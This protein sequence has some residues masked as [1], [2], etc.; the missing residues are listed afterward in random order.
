MRSR[1]FAPLRAAWMP[2]ARGRRWTVPLALAATAVASLAVSGPASANGARGGVTA[3][4]ASAA[5]GTNVSVAHSNGLFSAMSPSLQKIYSN[6]PFTLT[7]S[8]WQHHKFPKGPWKVGFIGYP[9]VNQYF[10][11]RLAGLKAEFAAAKKKGLVKGSLVTSLPAS[12]SDMT[13]ET[14]I[15]AIEQ[16]VNSGVNLILLEPYA[17]TAIASAIKYAASK[18][19]PVVL[20]DGLMPGSKYAIPVW[21]D[22][23]ASTE[24]GTL[25]LI[26]SGN[27]LFV[28]GVQGNTDDDAVYSQA[29]ADLKDCPKIKVE[30]VVYGDYATSTTKTVVQ[31]FLASHPEPLAGVLTQGGEFA[32]TVEAL[33]AEGKSVPPISDVEAAGGDL[34]W[35]LAHK[36]SYKTYGQ[37][38]NGAQAGYTFF[39]IALKILSGDE[40]KYNIIEVPAVT[41]DNSDLATYATAGK[42]LDWAGEPAGSKTAWCDQACMSQYFVKAGGASVN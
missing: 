27:I 29:L 7:S 41:F 16:M 1:M 37:G 11:D 19:V 9:S 3:S 2:H 35:W 6:D 5:C 8:Y 26:K 10:V 4:T 38:I 21:T 13:P 28:R 34:S 32:G 39:N 24:A 23:F 42:S 12:E 33:Q 15:S 36:S 40:P 14:Q 17:G 18:G 31:Q 22:N 25:G 30:G 20:A